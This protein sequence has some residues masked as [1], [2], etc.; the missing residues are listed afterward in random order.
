MN[1]KHMDFRQELRNLLDEETKQGRIIGFMIQGLIVA[2]L[3][4][5]AVQ[6]MPNLSETTHKVL[7]IVSIVCMLTFI[8]EYSLRVYTAKKLSKYIFSF[9]GI[10]DLLAIV[11][12]LLI[13]SG[14]DSSSLRSLRILRVFQLF[15]MTRYTNA[16]NRFK[17]A[18][19]MAKEELIF[20]MSMA[21]I[22]IFIASVGIHHFEA[23]A[24]PEA[25]GSIPQCMWWAV[26]TLTTLGYG[27]VY[28]I[29]AGGK[30]FTGLML[31][32]TLGIVSIPGA[33]LASSL[34]HTRRRED[35]NNEK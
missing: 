34:T 19:T 2:S 18:I 14:L 24:Q 15:K 26:V 32:G 9:Y 12:Y 16:I 33:M 1:I 27:E 8:T 30:V 3:F 5:L 22:I 11:P 29:T 20:F 7:E 10:I 31:L 13:G 25:F 23:V 6:S 4:S 17:D 28:P 21:V 35:E